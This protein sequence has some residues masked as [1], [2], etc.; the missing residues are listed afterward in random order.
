MRK[1]LLVIAVMCAGTALAQDSSNNRDYGVWFAAGHSVPGG[2]GAVSV[3]DGGVRMGWILTGDH[4]PGFLRGNFEYAID[5]V[6]AY[7]VH[8]VNNTYGAG[9]NPIDLKWNFTSKKHVIPYL[10]LGGGTLFSTH[11]VPAGTDRVNFRT[12]VGFGT[13]L[14]SRGGQNA[15]T[16]EARYEHISNAGLASPNPGINTVQVLVGFNTFRCGLF[17]SCSPK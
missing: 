10:E 16:L 17:R 12:H 1:M 11:D 15:V 5:L 9:F 14:K 2:T 8:Q 6:P 3:F 7:V 4:G 13:H